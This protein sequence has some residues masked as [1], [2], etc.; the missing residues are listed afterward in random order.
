MPRCLR[1]KSDPGWNTP[2]IRAPDDLLGACAAT[3]IPAAQFCAG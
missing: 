1:Q 2:L 3:P